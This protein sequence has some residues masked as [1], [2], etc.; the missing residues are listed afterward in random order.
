MTDELIAYL[1]DDLSPER[2]ASVEE[3]LAIDPAWRREL[4]RLQECLAAGADPGRLAEECADEPPQDLVARTCTLVQR[5]GEA[6]ARGAGLPAAA[7]TDAAPWRACGGRWS[8]TDLTVGAGVLL[9]LGSLVLPA[10]FES[11]DAAR[12]SVCQ[13]NLQQLGAALFNYQEVR[14]HRL[15]AVA[16]GENAGVYAVEL[17]EHGGLSREQLAELLLCPQ[18]RLADDVAAG[19]VV[20][21]IPTRREFDAAVGTARAQMVQ[22]MGGSFAYRL[23]YHENGALRQ[24]FFTGE[25]HLPLVAD[26]PQFSESGVRGGNHARGHNVLY[27]CLSVSFRTTCLLPDRRDNFYLNA[28]ERPAAGR[29]RRDVVLGGNAIGPDGPL[30]PV[31]LVRE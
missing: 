10:M 4:A 9:L 28:D 31:N 25:E 17:L 18:S 12:R 21:I 26:A 22:T 7:F 13:N 8:L 2:R 5:S 27:E 19:R 24:P 29:H 6:P 15:P 16:A 3:K 11:R 1:L 14:D 20:L 30:G 23:G